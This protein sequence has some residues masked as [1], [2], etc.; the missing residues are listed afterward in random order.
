MVA[1]IMMV[2]GGC[3]S[4]SAEAAWPDPSVP[5]EDPASFPELIAPSQG[6]SIEPDRRSPGKLLRFKSEDAAMKFENV[7]LPTMSLYSGSPR[8][9]GN[10]GP[11]LP[12]A[13]MEPWR[14]F[15]TESTMSSSL[16]WQREVP[17]ITD[18]GFPSLSGRSLR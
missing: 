14:R 15:E 3:A 6:V 7:P 2:S 5:P 17:G 4:I 9:E 1:G 10:A 11:P 8:R 12:G 16:Y 18:N 13:L